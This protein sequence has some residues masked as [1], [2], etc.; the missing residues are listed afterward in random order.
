MIGTSVVKPFAKLCEKRITCLLVTHP[1]GRGIVASRFFRN[2]PNGP[3]RD[4]EGCRVD[5]ERYLIPKERRCPAA[6]RRPDRHQQEAC[7]EH[8]RG[9]GKQAVF[10]DEIRR[11][12]VLR[13]VKKSSERVQ[14]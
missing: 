6:K 13:P 12:S 11:R 5:D 9:P 4:Q 14:Q 8:Q 2:T 1:L 7:R 10:A 3:C